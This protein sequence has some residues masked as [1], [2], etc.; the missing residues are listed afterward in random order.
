VNL[1]A[2]N[3]M[4]WDSIA[5]ASLPCSLRSSCYVLPVGRVSCLCQD[6]CESDPSDNDLMIIGGRKEESE[7]LCKEFKSAKCWTLDGC[8][9]VPFSSF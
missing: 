8:P 5:P 2:H 7:P 4:M 9:K 3:C 1:L 6:D